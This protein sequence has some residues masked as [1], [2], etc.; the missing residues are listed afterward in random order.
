MPTYF[1]SNEKCGTAIQYSVTKP[2][3]C[4]KCGKLL[5]TPGVAITSIKVIP[6]ADVA[7]LVAVPPAP[8]EEDDNAPLVA[9]RRTVKAKKVTVAPSEDPNL[10][11][12][13]EDDTYDRRAARRLA[14]ELLANIDPNSISLSGGD[15]NDDGPVRF[16]D[17]VR[18]RQA[19]ESQ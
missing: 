14:R 5:R 1:C 6:K 19:K 9:P 3:R 16:A 11:E 7:K 2:E 10:D 4:P 13:P 12:T 15:E 8:P 17:L 18:A